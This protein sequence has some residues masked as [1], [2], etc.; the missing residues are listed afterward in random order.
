MIAM[1]D[2]TPA[3]AGVR[4]GPAV[5]RGACA[6]TGAYSASLGPRP[7]PPVYNEALLA[8]RVTSTW[9]GRG[10]IGAAVCVGRN[11][12]GVAL[13]ELTVDE[14]EPPGRWVL[15]DRQFRPVQVSGPAPGWD[16]S[17]SRPSLSG[18]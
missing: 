18:W 15:I 14:V 9:R 7:G 6:G 8:M 10:T 1:R 5:G 12:D 3:M 16:T 2:L 4:S 17:G 13:W 11:E